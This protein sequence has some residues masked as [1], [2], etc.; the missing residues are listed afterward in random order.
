VTKARCPACGEARADDL[1]RCFSCGQEVLR[2]DR[3]QTG[4]W[5]LVLN[6]LSEDAATMEKLL[7][8]L[9]S[10]CQPTDRPL[11]FLTGDPQLYSESERKLGIAFPAVLLSG[12]SE[13]ATDDL[14]A[15]FRAQGFDVDAVEGAPS[16]SKRPA[17]RSNAQ[18]GKFAAVMGSV[19]A[20]WATV[21]ISHHLLA[22]V[23]VGVAF[24]PFVIWLQRRRKLAAARKAPGLFELK[25]HLAP[26]PVADSL[27]FDATTSAARI[28]APEVRALFAD[29]STELYRLMRRAADL[30]RHAAASGFGSTEQDLVNRALLA[31]RPLLQRLIGLAERI[32]T[33]D[34]ALAGTTE[35][36]LMASIARL[37]RAADAPDADKPG[38]EATRRDLEATLERRET[39]ELER[40]RLSAKL[41][42]LLGRLRTLVQRVYALRT[43]DE[44]EAATLEQAAAE[45][46][47][48]LA[49]PA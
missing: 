21:V 38:L 37:E 10:L 11:L 46:D 8:L 49:K 31:A 2:I 32:D 33:L 19:Y 43:P 20:G 7:W 30:D 45:L 36:E 15:L 47:A 39:T 4:A 27:L 3:A 14:E 1:P 23:A 12:L 13:S 40:A 9:S 26:V 35:G 41:C 6:T 22:G 34:A 44:E 29:V 24:L 48:F 25:E 28:R 42:E 18:A 16:N 17:S 5:R